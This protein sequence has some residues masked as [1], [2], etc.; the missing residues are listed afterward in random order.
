MHNL[1]A[2]FKFEIV[3]AIKKPTFWIAALSLPLIYAVF[4]GLGQ[5][6]GS[7]ARRQQEKLSKEE[8]VFQVTDESK[9]LNAEMLKTLGGSFSQDKNASIE[10]VKKGEIDAYY[11]IPANLTE[12]N[13]EVYAKDAGLFD[14]AKY[15]AILKGLLKNSSNESIEPNKIAIINDTIKIQ[16]KLYKNSKEYNQVKE[17]IAPGIFLVVFYFIVAAFSSRMLTS[18]T[19][20]KENRVT[21][22][23]LTSISARTLIVGKILALIVLGFL[24]MLT[25]A[26]PV[27]IGYFL[28]KDSLH[29]GDVSEFLTDIKFEFWPIFIGFLI[30]ITGFLSMTGFIV[31]LGS[32]M[33]TA[34]EAAQFV[35]IILMFM[36]APFFIFTAFLSNEVSLAVQIISFFP[37][38]SPIALL[39]R[40]T[41]G[42]LSSTDAIIG[43]SILAIFSVVSIW[44]A[45]RIFQSGAISYGSKVKLKSIFSKK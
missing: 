17:M 45:V 33:P 43:I 19:E 39:L 32:S 13:I 1:G 6:Q 31:A 8:I 38:T 41:L 22:M 44:F 18:T 23:I 40:N 28:L 34:Q 36:M 10:K 5:M 42:T 16:S 21:E 37:L 7:E 11:F 35:G 30:F 20:E 25:V 4:F 27:I 3:R 24:Q 14:S 29:L 15:S 2:V 12:Q 26:L 9:I